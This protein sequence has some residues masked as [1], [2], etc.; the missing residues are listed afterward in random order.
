[1]IIVINM[2]YGTSTIQMFFSSSV[3]SQTISECADEGLQCQM[4]CVDAPDEDPPF[5]CECDDGYELDDDGVSCGGKHCCHNMTPENK[6]Q[7]TRP[8]VLSAHCTLGPLYT[9]PTV[10]SAHCTFSPLYFRPTAPSSHCSL[11]PLY[12]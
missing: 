4:S 10:H 12:I 2:L 8:T 11:G 3:S 5:A 7:Y 1:M 9:R 6:R